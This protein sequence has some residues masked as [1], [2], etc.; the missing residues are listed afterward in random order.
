MCLSVFLWY[1]LFWKLDLASIHL[2]SPHL[3]P[4]NKYQKLCLAVTHLMHHIYTWLRI[5]IIRPTYNIMCMYIWMVPCLTHYL[6]SVNMILVR[7]IP[8]LTWP[9]E[10]LPG[11]VRSARSRT[12]NST[13]WWGWTTTCSCATACSA[14]TLPSCQSHNTLHTC[15]LHVWTMFDV[16]KK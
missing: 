10:C 6:A 3:T 1:L 5:N 8:A 7:I 14:S 12:L 13:A 15:N 16:I 11:W 9:Q 4:I 2:T